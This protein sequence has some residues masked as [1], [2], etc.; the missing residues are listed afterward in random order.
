MVLEEEIKSWYDQR[1]RRL[2]EK[3]WRPPYAYAVFLNHLGVVPGRKLLD[4]GC[5]TGHLLKIADERGLD[6]YGV[7]ISE[8]GVVIAKRISPHSHI[9][10]GRGEYLEYPD[11]FFDYIVCIGALEHFLDMEKGIREMVRVAKSGA[12][13]CIVVPNSNHLFFW[14]GT[15]GTPQQ[16]ILERLLSLKE[17]RRIFTNERLRISGVYQDRWFAE[18]TPLLVSPNPAAVTKQALRR[19]LWAFL[20]MHF[21]YQFIFVMRKD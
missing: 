14:I 10:V 9:R 21:A 8:E 16:D 3:A 17:W 7:D 19:I 18:Q 12:R 6:T 11:S 4:I 5:G 13:F 2:G 1:H 15:K 20:P